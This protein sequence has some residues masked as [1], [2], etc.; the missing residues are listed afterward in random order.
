MACN[1]A[2]EQT[3]HASGV[4]RCLECGKCTAICPIARHDGG[5][6]PRLTVGR[7]LVRRD[8]EL[9]DDD[10]L[11]ACLNCLQCSEV[12]PSNVDYASLTLAV[13]AA[14]RQRGQAALCTHGEAIHVWMRMMT[15]PELKQNR[16]EWLS[17]DL[18][19]SIYD[20][21]SGDA[22]PVTRHSSHDTLFFAG[23]APHYDALFAPLGVKGTAVAQAS[24][25]ILNA[26]DIE[27]QVLADERCCGHDL[28]WEGD[29][30]HFLQLARLPS[31]AQASQ[32]MRASG[33]GYP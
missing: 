25:R 30:D 22:S 24:V 11:W 31:A 19:F 4:L 8:E 28:L 12:C 15:Q 2:L 7:A 10:R 9:L 33:Q 1:A 27:P 14:A 18:R 20:F 26:L 32:P 29:I 13:R 6:S 16:L 23:C 5:F 17:P 3:I 21:R